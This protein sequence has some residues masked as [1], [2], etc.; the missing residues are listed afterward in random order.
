MGQNLKILIYS[1]IALYYSYYPR[2]SHPISSPK[3]PGSRRPDII[4]L[5]GRQIPWLG[6]WWCRWTLQTNSTASCYQHW[7]FFLP[8]APSPYP[9][10]WKYVCL[11]N[12]SDS[13]KENQWCVHGRTLAHR[14]CPFTWAGI[15]LHSSKMGKRARL[16]RKQTAHLTNICQRTE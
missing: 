11:K 10:R 15:C 8:T 16:T 12:F 2:E 1:K 9:G 5:H 4:L 3:G 14:S 7:Q 13:K 6:Y